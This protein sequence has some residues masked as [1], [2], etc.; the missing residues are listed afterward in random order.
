MP[1]GGYRRPP[2]T[3]AVIALT[4]REPLSI[5]TQT[6]IRAKLAGIYPGSESNFQIA[7]QVQPNKEGMAATAKATAELVGFKLSS[8]DQLD[9]IILTAKDFTT[10]RVAPYLGWTDLFAKAKANL[11]VLLRVTR[12]RNFERV[13]VRYINRLDIPSRADEGLDP[14]QYLLNLPSYP[15]LGSREFSDMNAQVIFELNRPPAR[16]RVAVAGI[17]S[18][19]IDHKSL[20]LDIDVFCF[21]KLPNRTDDVN[22]LLEQLHVAKNVIFE[23]CITDRARE[24]FDHHA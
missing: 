13:A 4:F 11:E 16:A 5:N 2:I 14:S 15:G 6:R 22:E 17:P 3:E 19:L 24:L 10:S 23:T 20:I 9:L 1:P 8:P 7:V 18:P 21:E 12:H